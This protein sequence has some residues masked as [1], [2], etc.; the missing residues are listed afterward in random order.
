MDSFEELGLELRMLAMSLW[1]NSMDAKAKLQSF[2]DQVSAKDLK[3]GVQI[4]FK[5]K[6]HLVS[7][8]LIFLCFIENEEMSVKAMEIVS[9][10]SGLAALIEQLDIVFPFDKAVC[11]EQACASA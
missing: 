7:D 9:D 10:E 8:L 1:T 4:A 6:Q 3:K 5:K 11:A 2:T